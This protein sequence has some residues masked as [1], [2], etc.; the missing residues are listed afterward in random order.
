MSTP[1]V[2][3]LL[4]L[5]LLLSLS[6]C[7][8][9][10]MLNRIA[11]EDGYT[12]ALDQQYDAASGQLLDVYTPI[13]AVNAPTVVFFYGKRWSGGDKSEFRFV[14]QALASRGFVAVLPNVRHYPAVRF[15]VFV[16]D[17]AKAV[18]W[19][20]ANAAR[21]GGDP[22]KLFVMGHSSGAHIA[23]MLAL[24]EDYLKAVG[25]SRS[26]LKGMIGLAGP[27]DFMPITA[28]DLRDIFGPVDRFAYSQ[29]VFFVDGKN[30]PLQL[31]H[32]ANDEIVEVKSTRNLARAVAKAGGAVETVIYENLSHSMIIG[33][34][35]SFLRGRADV[36]D[37]VEEFIKREASAK[38]LPPQSEIRAT[39]LQGAPQR[40]ELVPLPAPEPIPEAEPLPVPDAEYAEPQPLSS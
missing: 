34:L 31:L 26:W 35:G 11:P 23:A 2:L 22:A 36:L 27:Y 17:G 19:A 4:S 33:A 8:S 14:G 21:H 28:P 37:Q 10:A 18:Q 39:P 9:P 13:G 30:P 6:A 40:L 25:G 1:M 24:N 20:R 12:V 38:R 15:P 32:G 3:R 7:A 5:L 29:P 16:E